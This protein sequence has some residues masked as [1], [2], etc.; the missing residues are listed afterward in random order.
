L[1]CNF[2]KIYKRGVIGIKRLGKMNSKRINGNMKEIEVAA[3]IIG[4]SKGNLIER[5]KNYGTFSCRALN[6]DTNSYFFDFIY[7]DKKRYNTIE[8]GSSIKLTAYRGK[9]NPDKFYLRQEAA[10]K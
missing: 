2:H 10:L 9:N 7:V 8:R 3:V 4:K 6:P 5:L 1:R